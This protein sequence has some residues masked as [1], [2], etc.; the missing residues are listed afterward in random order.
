MKVFDLAF[1]DMLQSFRSLFAIAFMF[2]VPILLT[3]MFYLMFGAGDDE[4]GESDLPI[5]EVVIVNQ[6]QGVLQLDP[7]ALETFSQNSQVIAT[8]PVSLGELLIMILQAPEFSSLIHVQLEPDEDRAFQAVDQQ[9]AQVA[10]IIPVDFSAALTEPEACTSLTFYQDPTLTLGPGIVKGIIEQILVGFSSSKISLAV[11][12]QQL[13]AAGQ[14]VDAATTQQVLGSYY[15]A[16]QARGAQAPATASITVQSPVAQ[17]QTGDTVVKLIGLMMAGMTIFYVFFTGAS[18]AQ[19]I[20]KEEQA[21][22]LARLFTTPT[23]R[24]AILAGK[25]LAIV[26]TILVQI[27]VLLVFGHYVFGIEWGRLDTIASIAAGTIL[28]AAS[29]G[30]FLIS[31]V[32]TERQAGAAIG[33]VV[34]VMGMLGMLPIFMFDAPNPPEFLLTATRFVPQ[35]WAV[36]GLQAAME[37]GAP[38]DVIGNVLVLLAWSIAFFS[39]GVFR[40]RTRFA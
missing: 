24:S 12:F 15:A 30:I 35:G 33:G 39:I 22:T 2:I 5:T 13:Q 37:G 26:F 32:K 3:G 6:D 16:S 14:P 38:G 8:S 28:A 40:F 23:Q 34:T 18:G 31:W 25:L 9:I 21:G 29:F 20:L 27:S 10:I 19:T 4:T 1:K 11:T 7:A 36:Q 17:G